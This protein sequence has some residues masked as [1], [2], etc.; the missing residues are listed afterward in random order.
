MLSEAAEEFTKTVPTINQLIPRFA[1]P[2]ADGPTAIDDHR[3]AH[4]ERVLVCQSPVSCTVCVC[5][6]LL[7]TVELGSSHL[8][9][10]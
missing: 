8:Y 10:K 3:S 5:L 4:S 2:A 6:L 9:R 7:N 1:P